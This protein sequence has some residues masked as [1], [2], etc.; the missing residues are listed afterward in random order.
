MLLRLYPHELLARLRWRTNSAL[1]LGNE[2][3]ANQADTIG[4]ALQDA[5]LFHMRSQGLRQNPADGNGSGQYTAT[6]QRQNNNLPVGRNNRPPMRVNES[7]TGV[8]MT[9]AVEETG[10][11]QAAG[12]AATLVRDSVKTVIAA[13]MVGTAIEF[14]TSTPTAPPR[15][16]T[17]SSPRRTTPPSHC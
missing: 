17:S 8:T 3:R 9:A 16:R 12:K 4:K 11:G 7:K 14:M 10:L 13:S 15:P 6:T 2:G 5:G 1:M